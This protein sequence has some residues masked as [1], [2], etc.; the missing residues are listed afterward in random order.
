M[1]VTWRELAYADDSVLKT[2]FDAHTILQATSN[3]T[4]V[5]LTVAEQTIV[6]R[7]TSGNIKDLTPTEVRTLINV[8]DGADVT[9][10]NPPQA[11]AGNHKNGQSDE[12]LLNEFGE[13][14]GAVAINGQEIQDAIVHQVADSTALNNLTPVI[15]KLAMQVDTLAPYICTVAT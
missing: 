5:A 4:P 14:T 3:D 8:A 2:L 11:H 13:P 12:I 10:S 1:S 15:G 7:I 6:G 9:G